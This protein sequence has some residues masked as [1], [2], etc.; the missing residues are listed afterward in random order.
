MEG[1]KGAF[2]LGVG[3]FVYSSVSSAVS[4]AVDA[5]AWELPCQQPQG[6]AQGFPSCEFQA[7]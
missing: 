3:R 1:N 5:A 2:G 6:H 7:G 4:S